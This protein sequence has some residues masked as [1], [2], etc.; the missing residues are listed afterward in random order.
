VTMPKFIQILGVKDDNELIESLYA[1]DVAGRIWR[2][3]HSRDCW[4]PFTMTTEDDLAND[5]Q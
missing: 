5:D 2:F 3:N 4:V 1:L